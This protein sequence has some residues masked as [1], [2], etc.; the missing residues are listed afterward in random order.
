MKAGDDENV[1]H[2]GVRGHHPQRSLGGGSGHSAHSDP[3]K[4]HPK[5]EHTRE[6]AAHSADQEPGQRE[7]SG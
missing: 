6:V 5:E 4:P 7:G 3:V 2:A 1:E